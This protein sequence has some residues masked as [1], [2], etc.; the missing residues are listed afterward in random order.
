MYTREIISPSEGNGAPCGALSKTEECNTQPCIT[1]M[2][3]MRVD[4]GHLQ[5][6]LDKDATFEV[7]RAST[8][9]DMLAAATNA[10]IASK[11][12]P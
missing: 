10:D 9:V 5:I 2:P 12:G 7:V 4:G 8:T 1:V 6:V 11:V 3:E